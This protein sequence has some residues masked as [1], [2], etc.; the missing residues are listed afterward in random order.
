VGTINHVN[1]Y[2]IMYSL[3]H[4]PGRPSLCQIYTFGDFYSYMCLTSCNFLFLLIV[5][6][7]TQV[8]MYSAAWVRS[9]SRMASTSNQ[10]TW[11][12]EVDGRLVVDLLRQV[13]TGETCVHVCALEGKGVVVV[14][15]GGGGGGGVGVGMHVHMHAETAFTT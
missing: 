4:E 5:I 10:E 7:C 15:G 8:T 6:L 2:Y 9:Q 13:L 11:R 14:V 3:L 1:Y 12:A